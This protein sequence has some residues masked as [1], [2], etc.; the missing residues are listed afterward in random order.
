MNFFPKL[1]NFWNP[2]NFASNS[3]N[4]FFKIEKLF[5]NM[6][7]SSKFDYFFNFVNFYSKLEKKLNLCTFFPKTMKFFRI[8]F[9]L[10]RD[11]FSK[12]MNFSQIYELFF[13]NPWFYFFKVHEL[14]TEIWNFSY[15]W[16]FW[17]ITFLK[18]IFF[19]YKIFRFSFFL[20]KSNSQEL[21]SNDQHSMVVLS[22][23]GA[24]QA[25]QRASVCLRHKCRAYP[26][27]YALNRSTPLK[28]PAKYGL[29]WLHF[30][31]VPRNKSSLGAA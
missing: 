22:N 8:R 28:G 5:S 26:P 11:L 20:Q 10:I 16:N 31:V 13:K 6:W 7:T 27:T 9:F 3:M 18:F 2:K 14:F 21:T 19:F 17:K 30:W 23:H 25:P 29:V 12:S 24:D 1:M 4:C 15:S